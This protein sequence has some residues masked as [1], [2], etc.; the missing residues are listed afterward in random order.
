MWAQ[1]PTTLAPLL[2]WQ[3]QPLIGFV[4]ALVSIN[5]LYTLEDVWRD[6]ICT[7]KMFLSCLWARKEYIPSSD[8]FFLVYDLACFNWYTP[9]VMYRKSSRVN[10]GTSGS[11][12]CVIESHDAFFLVHL[13]SSARSRRWLGCE[14]NRNILSAI[15]LLSQ[16]G[17]AALCNWSKRFK[18]RY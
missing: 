18:T 10:L 13:S 16:K 1:Q 2:H 15:R 17:I 5:K 6:W 3:Y 14:A 8:K 12:S 9:S 7:L 11:D 4:P